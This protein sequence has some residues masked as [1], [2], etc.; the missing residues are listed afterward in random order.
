MS[1]IG[2]LE[3]MI[4]D[5]AKVSLTVA[6]NRRK[7]TLTE[8]QQ[9]DSSVTIHGL[10]EEVIVIK[11]DAFRSPD[12]VFNGSRGECKRADFVIIADT[13]SKKIILCIEIKAVK[14]PNKEI[15]QQLMGAQCFA[16][17]CLEIGRNFW[18][19]ESVLKGYAYRFV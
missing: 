6:G 15:I 10:P 11:A 14:G 2:I 8:P 9:P 16:A 18:S 3:E 4:K 13:I 1:D 7:V 12:T 19:E 5:A 17:Y